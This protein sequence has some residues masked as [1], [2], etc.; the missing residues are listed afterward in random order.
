[1]PTKSGKSRMKSIPKPKIPLEAE[2]EIMT[3][4]A[5][6]LRISAD[7]IA[8][9][10]EKHGVRADSDA[11]QYAYRRRVGQK[12]MASIR[13]TA[14]RRELLASRCEKGSIEYVV[15]NACNDRRELNAIHS[16]I[17]KSIAGLNASADKVRA[18]L[19]FLS[20]FTSPILPFRKR[21]G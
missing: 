5:R 17:L 21:K 18:R 4:L 7:D 8:Y 19:G 20:R 13:D 3:L 9:I 1:M 6:D 2:N 10:L 11:L 16:R 14:G 12:L 15:I